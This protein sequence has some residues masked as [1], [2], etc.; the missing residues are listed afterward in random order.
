MD[1]MGRNIK[2]LEDRITFA[3]PAMLMPKVGGLVPSD[4]NDIINGATATF[5]CIE[6][7]VKGQI[8]VFVI[9]AAH[10]AYWYG[11]DLSNDIVFVKLPRR[12]VAAGVKAVYRHRDLRHRGPLHHDFVIVELDATPEGVVGPFSGWPVPIQGW[13]WAGL[14][15][16][17]VFGVS[18]SGIVVGSHLTVLHYKVPVG[19]FL[20]TH[21]EP[22][23][24]GTL[25]HSNQSGLPTPIGSYFGLLGEPK[26]YRPRGVCV[27]IPPLDSPVLRRT[28]PI[29]PSTPMFQE[30]AY[31]VS[32][33]ATRFCSLSCKEGQWLLEADGEWETGVLVADNHSFVGSWVCGAGQVK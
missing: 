30:Y 28:E 26:G 22:G 24:S 31:R 29:R 11:K 16:S 9:G 4:K 8:R 32:P 1:F 5:T 15:N 2:S 7:R 27:P 33:Q 12:V 25:I 10:C 21:G 23:Q 14:L 3:V 20:E 18:T 17:G 19:V 13:H 6:H